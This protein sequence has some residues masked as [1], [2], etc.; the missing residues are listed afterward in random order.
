MKTT[1]ARK[2]KR[3]AAVACTDLLAAVREYERKHPAQMHLPYLR[4][5]CDG[6]GA[7]IVRDVEMFEFYNLAELME[8]LKAANAADEP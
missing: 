2:R 6:S 7:L 5:F 1:K 8:K 4:L 3:A